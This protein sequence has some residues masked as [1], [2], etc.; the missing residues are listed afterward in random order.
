MLKSRYESKRRLINVHMLALLNLPVVTR[1]SVQELQSIRER[2][3]TAVAAL[4]NLARK[5]EDLWNDMLVCLISQK[6]DSVSKAKHYFNT[7]P[8]FTSKSPNQHRDLVKQDKRCFN[9]LSKGHDV[10]ACKSKYTCR[11]CQKR[12]HTML[13]ADSDFYFKVEKVTTPSSPQNSVESKQTEVNSLFASSNARLRSHVLLA[14]ARVQV[15]ASSGRTVSVRAL[16]DQGS[17]I[18]FI[19]ERLAQDLKLKRLRMPISI[20]AVGGVDAGGTYRH[21]ARI[22]ISPRYKSAPAFPTTALI[23]KTLTS[24][25]PK[26]APADSAIDHLSD[27]S[28]AD[29]DPMSSDPIDILIGADLYSE[30]ILEGVRKS[31]VGRP[32]A[33]NTVLGW[34]ISEPIASSLGSAHDSSVEPVQH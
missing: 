18:T 23:L 20:S 21:A 16:L 28:W 14:T 17:E 11:R 10:H 34:V 9:C 30:L 6:L 13:H 2:V 7:Y 29:D 15:S 8:Q 33:Q 25:S 22:K 5:P 4:K 1:E 27:L 3:N 26:R 32:I 19:T 31:T 12:H 24:Y